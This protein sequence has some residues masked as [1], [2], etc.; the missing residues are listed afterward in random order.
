MQHSPGFLALVNEAKKKI[1]E[2]S[3]AELRARLEVNPS[4]VL[5]DVREDHEWQAG[6]ARGA[7]HLGRG[8]FERDLERRF[9]DKDM[10]LILYCG[11]G[12]RSALAAE[13]AQRMGYRRVVSLIGGYRALLMAGWPVETGSGGSSG[14][15]NRPADTGG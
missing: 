3:V 15:A 11:G 2:I 4:A 10:E 13:S 1:T 8:I 5:V 9:P 7:V 12:Y 14:T 6:H